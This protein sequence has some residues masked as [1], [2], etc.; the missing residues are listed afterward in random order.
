MRIRLIELLTALPTDIPD[1][2]LTLEEDGMYDVSWYLQQHLSFSVSV[3]ETGYSFAYVL[4]EGGSGH[5]FIKRGEE[6]ELIEHIQRFLE[7]SMP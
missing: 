5:G 3:G 2:D 7:W 6:T 1:P 4:P